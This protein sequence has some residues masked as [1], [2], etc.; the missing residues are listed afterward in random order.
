M[1]DLINKIKNYS[2]NTYTMPK[3]VSRQ[4]FGI[5]ASG[6]ANFAEITYNDNDNVNNVEIADYYRIET[7]NADGF[8]IPNYDF[9]SNWFLV[10]ALLKSKDGRKVVRFAI[11]EWITSETYA[12]FETVGIQKSYKNLQKFRSDNKNNDS[13]R[14]LIYRKN[15][16]P[17]SYS[18]SSFGCGRYMSFQEE[19]QEVLGKYFIIE[20]LLEDETEIERIRKM[21]VYDTL[22]DKIIDT[23]FQNAFT[24]YIIPQSCKTYGAIINLFLANRLE[25]KETWGLVQ[26]EHHLTCVNNFKI[27]VPTKVFDILMYYR[28]DP[29]FGGTEAYLFATNYDIYEKRYKKSIKLKNVNVK[30]V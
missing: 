28:F 4:E 12:H 8:V 18:K 10:L 25:P 9:E 11:E 16:L 1:C 29:D 14:H 26:N 27:G 21:D 17:F 3:L 2:K 19:L 13:L 15:T 30:N 20:P 6:E 7:E 22:A 23:Y 24:S 5:G